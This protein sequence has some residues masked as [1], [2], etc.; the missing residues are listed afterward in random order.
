VVGTDVQR[1]INSDGYVSLGSDPG[2]NYSQVAILNINKLI[3]TLKA[4]LNS[5]GKTKSTD[6]YGNVIYVDCDIFSVNMLTTFIANAL[7]DFNQTPY[8]SNFTFNDTPIIDQFHDI[9]VEGATLMALASQQLIERGREYTIS[10]NGVSFTPP[11]ISEAI[12][13]QYSTLITQYYDKLK[14]I[15]NNLRSHPIGL[16]TFSMQSAVNPQFARLRHL[17]QRRIV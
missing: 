1:V 13:T 3:K 6:A 8:F 9:L 2:F 17:R 10:D 15:K 5:S 11:T 7:S 14:F 16:G 4:R 12:G